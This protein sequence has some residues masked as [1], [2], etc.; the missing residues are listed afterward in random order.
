MGS[1]FNSITGILDPVALHQI[2]I[3]HTTN[4]QKLKFNS[5]YSQDH[6]NTLSIKITNIDVEQ[7]TCEKYCSCLPVILST[8][9]ASKATAVLI[10]NNHFNLFST[11]YRKF[12]IHLYQQKMS[13]DE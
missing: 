4:V 9:N 11:N 2:P 8:I 12:E 7:Y 6:F 1:I 10:N 13:R 5:L 3:Q